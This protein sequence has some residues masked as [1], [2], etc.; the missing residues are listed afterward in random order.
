M[1]KGVTKNAVICLL[2]LSHEMMTE[3]NEKA[4]SRIIF[5]PFQKLYRFGLHFCS[6]FAL[7][8]DSIPQWYLGSERTTEDAGGS[9]M[10]L[11]WLI[12]LWVDRDQEVQRAASLCS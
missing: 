7:H 10:G 2:H 12:P 6:V 1:G 9:Q 8:Q 3:N 11:A 5:V 4:S